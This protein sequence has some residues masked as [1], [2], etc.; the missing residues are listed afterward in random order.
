MTNI[1]RMYRL[2]RQWQ[3]SEHT[4]PSEIIAVYF[5]RL[6]SHFVS[7]SVCAVYWFWRDRQHC[8]PAHPVLCGHHWTADKMT[9]LGCLL[10][11]WKNPPKKNPSHCHACQC[12][13]SAAMKLVMFNICCDCVGNEF[14][15]FVWGGKITN[16]LEHARQR[17]SY[18]YSVDFDILKVMQ[19]LCPT[20][21]RWHASTLP[22]PVFTVSS[23]TPQHFAV[24]MQVHMI[25]RTLANLWKDIHSCR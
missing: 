15:I 8:I 7:F 9:C 22:Q 21:S 23:P 14:F 18:R 20:P 17:L 16:P 6:L 5:P 10:S 19:L 25:A 4:F 3:L 24:Q 11:I 1:Y 13:S 12:S 2:S